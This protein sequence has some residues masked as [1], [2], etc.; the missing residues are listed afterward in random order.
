MQKVVPVVFESLGKTGA[1]P[2]KDYCQNRCES[3][4]AEHQT[5]S[6]NVCLAKNARSAAKPHKDGPINP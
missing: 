3:F 5:I 2:E 1:C 6:E 4:P